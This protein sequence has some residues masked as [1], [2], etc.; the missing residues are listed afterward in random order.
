[1]TSADVARL[2]ALARQANDELMNRIVPFWLALEDKRHGG[3]F[4][5]VDFNGDI[6]RHEK[7]TA[8]FVARLLFFSPKSTA[9]S[10][11]PRPQSTRHG[12]SVSCLI[13]SKIVFMAGFFGR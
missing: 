11:T 7:K 10:A 13:D 12:P 1:M 4:S 9:L 5:S 8:V 2:E 6:D 3:Y